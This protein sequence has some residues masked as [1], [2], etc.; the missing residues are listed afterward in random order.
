[1]L[2]R[3]GTN[4]ISDERYQAARENM[5]DS[6]SADYE[7]AA[8]GRTEELPREMRARH[9]AE[10]RQ[11]DHDRKTMSVAEWRRHHPDTE[12]RETR[13]IDRREAATAFAQAHV[14]DGRALQKSSSE[15]VVASQKQAPKQRM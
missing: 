11:L 1:M 13:E 14:S 8:E 3:D 10:A 2:M 7:R 9:S 12:R 6:H 4:T 5:R 15:T